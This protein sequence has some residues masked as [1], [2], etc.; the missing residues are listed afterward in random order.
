M[1]SAAALLLLLAACAYAE[2]AV[3][4]RLSRR[5][6]VAQSTLDGFSEIKARI[7]TSADAGKESLAVWRDVLDE[8]NQTMVELK[9][10]SDTSRAALRSTLQSAVQA[11][12]ARV[13][14]LE[15]NMPV[16]ALPWTQCSFVN[17]NEG[18]DSGPIAS[19][20]FVKKSDDSVLQVTWN[21]DV[22]VV[23]HGCSRRFYLLIDDREC[24]NP[25]AIDDMLHETHNDNHHR[26]GYISGICR[27][28][29]GQAIPAGPHVLTLATSGSGD[30][31][32]GWT[33]T[34]RMIIE[35]RAP[36]TFVAGEVM[37]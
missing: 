26:P 23:C 24:T 2:D 3:S 31:F 29:G 37:P 28:A 4:Q 35:E 10:S 14:H 25:G 8:H 16:A 12:E 5:L 7:E 36:G 11:L 27:Q 15:N 32:A 34:S 33:S 6:D 18:T 20:T 17:L 22:R 21:G 30:A 13:T 9:E 19:C 1:R